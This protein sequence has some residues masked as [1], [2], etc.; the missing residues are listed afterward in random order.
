MAALGPAVPALGRTI[1]T[2][3]ANA[4]QP[5]GA[6]QATPSWGGVPL[7]TTSVPLLSP[8]LLLSAPQQQQQMVPPPAALPLSAHAA[9]W[10]AQGAPLAASSS[11]A[12]ANA[13][14]PS[15]ADIMGAR[16]EEVVPGD[17]GVTGLTST[18]LAASVGVTRAGGDQEQEDAELLAFMQACGTQCVWGRQA[19]PVWRQQGMPAACSAGS[20]QGSHAAETP[21]THLVPG[22][23]GG[24]GGMC[25]PTQTHLSL[26]LPPPLLPDNGPSHRSSS[27][28]RRSR[29]PHRAQWGHPTA[30]RPQ[31]APAPRPRQA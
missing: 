22:G 21:P 16:T 18:A 27:K 25:G 10:A 24:G 5:P 20:Q 8:L 11:A 19:G 23:R 17:S 3:I 1:I 13:L 26:S 31:R 4:P 7:S 6:Q 14:V 12:A 2:C 9:W 29:G 15:A 28:P 30:F